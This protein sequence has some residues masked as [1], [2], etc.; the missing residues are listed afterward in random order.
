MDALGHVFECVGVR[1]DP[2]GIVRQLPIVSGQTKSP[3]GIGA[4]TQTTIV[5]DHK[6]KENG[7][8]D[9]NFASRD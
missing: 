6:A 1:D 5:I 2:R 8:Y 9:S 3:Q 7:R 4:L